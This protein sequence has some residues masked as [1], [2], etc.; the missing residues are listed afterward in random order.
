MSKDHDFILFRFWEIS[1]IDLGEM[2]FF[3][4][5]VMKRLGLAIVHCFIAVMA[6]V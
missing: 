5:V 2:S 1:K 4:Y 3:H 6:Q